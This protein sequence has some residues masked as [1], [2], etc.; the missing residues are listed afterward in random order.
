M[1]KPKLYNV[2]L[3]LYDNHKEFLPNIK[4]MFE[5]SD[6]IVNLIKENRKLNKE[7]II[8]KVPLD[9]ACTKGAILVELFK[10]KDINV[11][12]DFRPCE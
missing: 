10:Q 11:E 2:V 8:A 1:Q 12:M 9:I 7:T 3:T 4:E 5:L 6:D